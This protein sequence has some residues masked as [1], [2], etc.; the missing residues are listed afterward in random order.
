MTYTNN[1]CAIEI[2]IGSDTT[3][4]N[5]HEENLL[6]IN[7]LRSALEDEYS[8]ANISV[9]M[10]RNDSSTVLASWFDDIDG[11]EENVN[12]IKNR[13]WDEMACFFD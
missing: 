8:N 3:G 5:T 1:L 2:L 9:E 12:L 7:A 10:S 11:V 13:V 4:E 6:F